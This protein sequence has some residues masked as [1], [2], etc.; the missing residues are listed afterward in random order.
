MFMVS[1]HQ[2]LCATVDP[3][4]PDGDRSRMAQVCLLGC[5]LVSHVYI[6]VRAGTLTKISAISAKVL[7]ANNHNDQLTCVISNRGARG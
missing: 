5:F 2:D 7:F 1:Y 3:K 6:H 4:A